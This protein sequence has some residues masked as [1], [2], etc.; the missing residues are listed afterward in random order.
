MKKTHGSPFG[1]SAFVALGVVLVGAA[2]VTIWSSTTRSSPQQDRL[3][4]VINVTSSLQFLSETKT[5]DSLVLEMKNA[6][7]KSI[8]AYIV[9]FG[10]GLH[11]PTDYTIGDLVV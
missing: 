9:S 8:V 6:S 11:V 3:P 5:S 10:P 4:E 7:T 1:R 2:L